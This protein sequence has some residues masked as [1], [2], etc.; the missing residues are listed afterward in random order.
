MATR[1]E[2]IPIGSNRRQPT[3]GHMT[4]TTTATTNTDGHVQACKRARLRN[5]RTKKTNIATCLSP[6]QQLT[7]SSPSH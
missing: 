7:T 4:K 3:R 6:P 1:C 2:Q 5:T